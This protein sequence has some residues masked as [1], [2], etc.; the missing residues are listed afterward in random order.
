MIVLDMETSGLD[1]VKSGIWQIGAID[2]N[3]PEDQFIEEARIDDDDIISDGALKVTGKTE[4]E[5]RDPNKQSQKEM[6]AKFIEWIGNRP[7]KNLLCQNPQWDFSWLSI[8]V[9]KYG[10]KKPFPYRTFDLHTLAQTRYFDINKKFMIEGEKSGMNLLN[11]LKFC[12]LK[13]DRVMMKNAEVIKEGKPHNALEDCKLE[14][15]CFFRL[16][17]GK[18]LFPEFSKFPVPGVLKK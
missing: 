10:L 16:V 8:R 4:E 7:M 18:N 15:E 17:Y 14:G 9:E 3:N 2:L 5:L 6:F 1:L 11:T 12:G 13:D